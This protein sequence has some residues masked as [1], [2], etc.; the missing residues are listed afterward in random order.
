MMDFEGINTEDYDD[1]SDADSLLQINLTL[2]DQKNISIENYLHDECDISYDK[3]CENLIDKNID[4]HY[5]IQN[6]IEL[7]DDNKVN[8]ISD[9]KE[10]DVIN[11]AENDAKGN[12][13]DE[14]QWKKFLK[15][16]TRIRDANIREIRI[17]KRIYD[18]RYRLK[19]R[20][21]FIHLSQIL[22]N[23]TIIGK[24]K[25]LLDLAIN[26]IINLKKSNRKLTLE[27]NRLKDILKYDVKQ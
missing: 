12:T 21:Q 24:K 18:N 9:E 3:I 23:K 1:F 22:I 2:F 7:N 13:V 4:D 16:R 14:K 10:I 17:S 25:E 19:I 15:T 8:F 27:N 20:K 5:I 26:F 6:L 11:K